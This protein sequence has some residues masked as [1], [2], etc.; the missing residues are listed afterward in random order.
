MGAILKKQL[1][2]GGFIEIDLMNVFMRRFQQ[3][4]NVWARK[5]GDSTWRHYLEPDFVVKTYFFIIDVRHPPFDEKCLT[6][7][8]VSAF[9][10]PCRATCCAAVISFVMTT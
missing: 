8:V 3:L 4:E 5:Y 10:H 1:S 2:V 6:F 9:G 7:V